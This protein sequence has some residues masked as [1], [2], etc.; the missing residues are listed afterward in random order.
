MNKTA[1]TGRGLMENGKRNVNNPSL[2]ARLVAFLVVITALLAACG[3]RETTVVV[4]Q[5]QESGISVSGNG[6]VTVRPDIAVLR[7]GVEVTR[8]TVAEAR[9]EAAS[10]MTMVQGS[11]ANNGVEERDINTEYFGINPEYSNPSPRSSTPSITGY[12]V[13]NQL[14]VTIRNI[15]Y[16]SGV[17]DQ[18]TVAGGDFVRVNG[19]SFTV[20]NPGQYLMQAREKAMDDAR[21]RANQ[22][23][24]L[25]S[26][27]LGDVRS[28]S[29]G[30][31]SAP[32]LAR[33]SFGGG[34]MSDF[35]E[36][37]PIAPGDTNI[38]SSVFVVYEIR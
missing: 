14:T 22:L 31:V 19:I 30:S 26:V 32:F 4:T 25:A 13:S 18:A 27:E 2:N 35:A 10:A 5:S 37:T 36:L 16:L 17:I 23:A 29:E 1:G 28:I 33:S 20:D 38:S 3:D 24:H 8:D 12:R 9:D 6:S 21:E 7:I 34:G 15:D 11:L